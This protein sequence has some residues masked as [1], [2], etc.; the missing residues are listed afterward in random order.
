MRDARPLSEPAALDVLLTPADFGAL[1]PARIATATCVVFDI[2]RATSTIVAAE[3]RSSWITSGSARIPSYS[4]DSRSNSARACASSAWRL[5]VS[6]AIL[7][8][9]MGDVFMFD[10]DVVRT[11]QVRG[12]S[13]PDRASTTSRNGVIEVDPTPTGS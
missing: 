8:S 2:L 4:A 1:D 12:R 10:L 11:G 3:S 5:S 9:G 6:A 7:S 13:D